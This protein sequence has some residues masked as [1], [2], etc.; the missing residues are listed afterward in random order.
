MKRCKACQ[1]DQQ[2]GIAQAHGSVVAC[3]RVRS[4][5]KQWWERAPGYVKAE[6]KAELARAGREWWPRIGGP[7]LRKVIPIRSMTE[8]Q[9]LAEL[10]RQSARLA[11]QPPFEEAA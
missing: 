3:Q 7:D 9:I 8:K 4:K 5:A 1:C 2:K 6:V 11:G 10:K